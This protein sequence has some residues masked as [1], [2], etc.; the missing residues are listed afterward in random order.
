MTTE[1]H[2]CQQNWYQSYLYDDALID[3]SRIDYNWVGLENEDGQI[4]GIIMKNMLIE[5][6]S[7]YCLE[8]CKVDMTEYVMPI[9]IKSWNGAKLY[10]YIDIL[11]S[12]YNIIVK[13][14]K[15]YQKINEYNKITD[16]SYD[17]YIVSNEFNDRIDKI[18]KIIFSN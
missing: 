10:Y 7:L 8:N 6:Q 3:F 18:L 9:K 11:F 4:I 5:N 16:K 2:N 14:L 12:I 1:G 13:E 17:F 15:E